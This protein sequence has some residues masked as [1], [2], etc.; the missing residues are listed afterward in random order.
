MLLCFRV[1]SIQDQ[2]PG[3][4]VTLELG[5]GRVVELR[6]GRNLRQLNQREYYSP[7]SPFNH[8]GGRPMSLVSCSGTLKPLE[9]PSGISPNRWLN[10]EY[11]LVQSIDMHTL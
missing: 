8:C 1:S 3:L 10:L 7:S 5:P 6:C 4:I 11:P 9:L 2:A